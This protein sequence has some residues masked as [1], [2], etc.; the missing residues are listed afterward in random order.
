[1][2]RNHT[3]R[4]RGSLFQLYGAKYTKAPFRVRDSRHRWEDSKY[5]SSVER[6]VRVDMLGINMSL[7][8][9][10]WA[11]NNDLCTIQSS[12]YNVLCFIDNIM[13]DYIFNV[14]L[15]WSLRGCLKI[16][17]IDA[18]IIRVRGRMQYSS[19]KCKCK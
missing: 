12:R 19:S 4:L 1:M 8:Y 16:K 9:N 5:M 18:R 15:E 6:R 3:D 7:M 2:I 10:G 17:R 14:I 11:V 13:I